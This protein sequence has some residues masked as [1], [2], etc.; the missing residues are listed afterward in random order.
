MGIAIGIGLGTSN[1]TAAIYRKGKVESI[2]IE[3]KS[4][5]PSVVSCK[6]DG[7]ILVGKSAYMDPQNQARVQNA[8]FLLY[9]YKVLHL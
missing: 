1:S 4:I 6:D 7:H 2:P 5:L 9:P 8:G 3:G